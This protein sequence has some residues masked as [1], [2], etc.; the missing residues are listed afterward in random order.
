MRRVE[1][2]KE[3]KRYE[4]DFKRNAAFYLIRN[5]KSRRQVALLSMSRQVKLL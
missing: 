2:S 1:M 3:K 4:E 5:I